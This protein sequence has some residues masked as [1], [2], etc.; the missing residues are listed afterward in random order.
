MSDLTRSEH[1][2]LATLHAASRL[3]TTEAVA[4]LRHILSVAERIADAAP[5]RQG[6]YVYAAQIPWSLIHELRAALEAPT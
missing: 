2:D 3:T 4:Q 5:K 6:K 1:L